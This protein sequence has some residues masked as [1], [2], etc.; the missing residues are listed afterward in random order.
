MSAASAGHEKLGARDDARERLIP[1]YVAILSQR[2]T[3]NGEAG[4]GEAALQ[5]AYDLG[6]QAIGYGLGALEIAQVHQEALLTVL[7]DH[8]E[9]KIRVTRAATAVLLEALT[10]IEMARRGFE[11]RLLEAE[12][13]AAIG[14][15]L[16]AGAHELSNP[17]AVIL[18]NAAL[19]R[20]SDL[21]EPAAEQAGRIVEAGE[22]CG[23]I[24]DSL[25]GLARQHAPDRQ[26]VSL[27]EVVR[28]ALP[29]LSYQFR[30]HE[31]EVA[32]DLAPELPP[33]WADPH[34]LRQVVVNLSAN[35]DQAMRHA[36]PPRRLRVATRPLPTRRVLLEVADN[37]PG[38]PLEQQRGVLEPVLAARPVGERTGLGL[39]LCR[40]IVEWHGGALLAESAPGQ[41][42]VFRIELP[43]GTAVEL[44]TPTMDAVA[45]AR[46]ARRILVVDDEPLVAAVLTE[47]FALDGHQV[48]VASHG[49]AALAKL[50]D[51][52]YD[53]VVS[54][55]RMPELDG[56]GL[57]RELT[58]R[59]PPLAR[60]FVFITGDV[61]DPSVMAFVRQT[62]AP[63]VRKP[64]LPDEVRRV[65]RQAL[66]RAHGD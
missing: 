23:R 21:G 39:P 53:V 12:K 43:V 24:V 10:P 40:R 35:A 25:L 3:G 11:A 42:A 18:G 27:N 29:L 38:L 32:L 20:E 54:D 36:P 7:R 61:V 58:R 57:Y 14:S 41:G 66:R 48:E 44:A 13:L 59:D 9:D 37:G 47:I 63:C 30:V 62:G 56:P 45:Q 16:S 1:Q 17:L 28:G 6:R 8:P 22:H 46:V 52:S 60:R 2:L 55:V 5:R 49:V 50:Q 65:I 51:G 64:F 19:M 15:V 33:L 31:V 26:M 34:Q 4:N